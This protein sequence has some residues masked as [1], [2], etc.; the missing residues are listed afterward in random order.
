MPK[1]TS[2]DVI[3]YAY[4]K[5][6]LVNTMEAKEVGYMKEHYKNLVEF[7]AG[8]DKMWE[9]LEKTQVKEGLKWD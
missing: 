4:L 2:L 8:M 3:A 9:R 1:L 6:E 7:V 5:E